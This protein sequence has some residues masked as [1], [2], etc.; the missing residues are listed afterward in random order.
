VRLNIELEPFPSLEHAREL[1]RLAQLVRAGGTTYGPAPDP[2]ALQRALL[3]YARRV[4]SDAERARAVR[5]YI[6]LGGEDPVVLALLAQ[7][8]LESA[9]ALFDQWQGWRSLELLRDPGFEA[10]ATTESVSRSLSQA[11]GVITETG[12]D[13]RWRERL[14]VDDGRIVSWEV[15]RDGDG[16]Q[17]IHLRF[18]GGAPS[19][20]VARSEMGVVEVGYGLYPFVE[21]AE[22]ALHSGME[23]FVL[24]PR[25]V[26]VRVLSTL[27]PQG[28][29]LSSLPV[30]ADVV[31]PSMA[32][33]RQSAVRVD[34]VDSDGVVVERRYHAGGD[35]VHLAHDRNGDGMWDT[36]EVSQGGVPQLRATDLDF[37]G[38]YEVLEG[39]RGGQRLARAIDE[40]EDGVPELFEREIG[41]S[42]REW[43]I[44]EDGRID[45]REFEGWRASV[46]R[47]FPFLDQEM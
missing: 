41:V 12:V 45:V 23:T 44:N 5:R 38:Y 4:T 39:F 33:L 14:I 46:V 29:T 3:R 9:V 6:D 27:P 8:D 11:S 40:N 13:G 31:L 16:V 43:D 42:V 47:D 37:D 22:V 20:L 28:P 25:A 19:S 10:L 15:D 32:T 26:E 17:E 36:V 24:R 1:D 2:A 18:L 7:F 34:L 35:R 21:S 30:L